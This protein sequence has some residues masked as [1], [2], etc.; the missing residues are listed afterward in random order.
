M[1]L[2]FK[3][4]ID[5]ALPN[6]N[7]FW[8]YTILIRTVE[9]EAFVVVSLFLL[10]NRCQKISWSWFSASSC[11]HCWCLLCRCFYLMTMSFAEKQQWVAML[12]AVT[13]NNK[14]S[15][16]ITDASVFGNIIF[17]MSHDDRRMDVMCTWPLS[18]DV[19]NSCFW[20]NSATIITPPRLAE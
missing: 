4:G 9:I 1:P 2:S 14:N 16:K 19:S 11:P 6:L 18:D 13:S 7:W 15:N 8:I 12:E 20:F 3:W 5:T 17:H 10:L